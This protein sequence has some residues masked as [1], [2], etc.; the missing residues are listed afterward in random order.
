M[1]LSVTALEASAAGQ[2]S[3]EHLDGLTYVISPKGDQFRL[4]RLE[5]IGKPPQPGEMMKL[6]MRIASEINQLADTYD[7]GRGANLFG[8][9]VAE[10]DLA[11]ADPFGHM[12]VRLRRRIGN[13]RGRPPKVCWRSG[14]KGVGT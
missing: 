14:T 6:P 3:I 7:E 8:P 9:S 10:L 2:K 13:V 5:R 12:R 11:S 1:P 4:D